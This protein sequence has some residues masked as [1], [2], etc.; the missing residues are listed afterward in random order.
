MDGLRFEW[1]EA[2]N[3]E[4]A[5]EHGVSFQEAHTVFL[6]ENAI[7]F[8]DPDHSQDEDRFI[9]LGMS[10]KLR[11]L[12]VCHCF[13]EKDTVIRIVSARKALKHEARSYGS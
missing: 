6:D 8:F 7:R 5:R 10:A 2:K 1:D 9:M 4:N 12:V 13:R 11:V 3:R